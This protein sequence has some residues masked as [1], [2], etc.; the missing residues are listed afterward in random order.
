MLYA[1][2]VAGGQG[3]RLWPASRKT[4]PK[5]LS[6]F[7]GGES[8]LQRTYKRV[9]KLIPHERI[10]IETNSAYA[11][12]FLKQIPELTPD[13]LILE[14]EAKNNGPAVG[15]AAAVLYKVNPEAVMV[16]VWSDHY[17]DD[18]D[19]YLKM[20]E[21]A[22]AE[23]DK[24][25]DYLIGIQAIPT[26]PATGFGYLE[27]GEVLDQ[28]GEHTLYQCKQFVEKPDLATAEQYL[29]A[30][31]F[32]WNTASY[33]WRV[34]T[35]LDNFKKYAPDMY[36]GL[37]KMAEAWGTTDWTA[38]VA[39]EFGLFPSIGFEYLI[40]EKTDKMAFIPAK[41]GWKDVGSWQVVHE[42]LAKGSDSDVVTKGKVI[43]LEAENSL[44]FNENPGK[45]VAVVG[46]DDLVIVDTPDALL[47]MKK[48]QDQDVKKATAKIA[49]MGETEY[50]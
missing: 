43:T 19:G 29:A 6:P 11:E 32:Y 35:V 45:L 25:P 50:L 41:I 36:A 46:V 28:I 5:Q 37:M 23:A 13:R 39:R 47:V 22:A 24:Y 34:S 1:V 17:Y 12:E 27:A 10:Y 18:E 15:L 38:V 48:S 44:I 20:V 40:S 3:T 2:I 49:E 8:L 7:A 21:L 33:V 26:Y 9:A 14:P 42:I 30:G 31:N 16:N 4:T